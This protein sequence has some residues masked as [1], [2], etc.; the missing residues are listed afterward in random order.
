MKREQIRN[1]ARRLFLEQGFAGSST[2]AIAAAAE[3]SKQTLYS[4]YPSKEELLA[5]VLKQLVDDLPHGDLPLT[6]EALSIDDHET[7]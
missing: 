5:D 4:Y 7:L 2:D 3:V 1:G 6:V